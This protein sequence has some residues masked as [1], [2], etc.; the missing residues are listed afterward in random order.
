[1]TSSCQSQE[2]RLGNLSEEELKLLEDKW[3][4]EGKTASRKRYLRYYYRNR[5]RL[6]TERILVK[7][8][9]KDDL[10]ET[11]HIQSGLIS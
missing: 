3:N 11:V 6:I 1:M 5:E 10:I 8:N 4:Q 2:N 9:K 7:R